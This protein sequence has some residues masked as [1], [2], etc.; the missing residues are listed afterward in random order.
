MKF[1]DVLLKNGSDFVLEITGKAPSLGQARFSIFDQ[2]HSE[3]SVPSSP[4]SQLHRAPLV[5]A[6][7]LGDLDSSSKIEIQPSR[8]ELS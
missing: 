2:R 1:F 4:P 8:L 7:K 6:P 3:S 5:P